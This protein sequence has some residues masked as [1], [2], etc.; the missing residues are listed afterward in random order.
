MQNLGFNSAV[1][2]Y[3]NKWSSELSNI[4]HA[5]FMDLQMSRLTLNARNNFFAFT[6]LI[7]PTPIE[8]P[9]AEGF[10]LR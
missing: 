9:G 4:K 2:N 7:M 10:I 3:I 8:Q 6:P 5:A 1:Q